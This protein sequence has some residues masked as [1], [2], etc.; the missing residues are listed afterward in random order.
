MKRKQEGKHGSISGPALTLA[1]LTVCMLACCMIGVYRA[2]DAGEGREEREESEEKERRQEED[3]EK[4]SGP[5]G[6]ERPASAVEIRLEPEG[7]R[8]N[9]GGVRVLENVITIREGGH[10]ILTGS[11]TE[12]QICVDAGKQDAVILELAGVDL[13]RESEPVLM[14]K[15]AGDLKILLAEGTQNMLRSGGG[16]GADGTKGANGTEA[17]EASGGA[18]YAKGDLRIVGPGALK[19]QGNIHNGIHVTGHLTVESG[20][21]EVD[22]VNH[23]IKGRASVTV[24][25][26]ELLISSGGDGIKSDGSGGADVGCVTIGGGAIRVESGD[27]GVQ[28]ENTLRITEGELRIQAEGKGLRAEENLQIRGGSIHVGKSTEGLECRHILISGG[29]LEVISSDD[30]INACGAKGKESESRDRTAEEDSLPGLRITGGD[31]LVCAGGDGLDSN[32]NILVEGGEVRIE[33]ASSGH[34]GA[35]DFGVENGGSCRISG[36]TLIAVGSGEQAAGF[37][38]TYGQSSFL[39]NF[40]EP[41]G[42]GSEIT[43]RNERDALLF[44]YTPGKAFSS[45]VFSSPELEGGRIYRL[46]A[47]EQETEIRLSEKQESK[48]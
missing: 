21:L 20:R 15:R 2:S 40:A 16:D 22:A 34:D 43:I 47:G 3:G 46:K 31:I 24:N 41:A 1:L 42:P 9:G 8:V 28:A 29:E 32:G 37:D 33:G 25:G 14:V 11:M 45:V 7:I 36:G 13:A 27:D 38:E 48:R 23:G 44:R 18:L 17:E 30:G 12:G 4:S 10:Y 6:G 5:E 19:I 35:L 39:H 26:G